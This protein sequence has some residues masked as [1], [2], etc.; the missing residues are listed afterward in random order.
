MSKR[1]NF[2]TMKTVKVWDRL[3]REVMQSSDLISD[4][5]LSRG[6]M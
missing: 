5:V 1:E 4:V 6:L 2:F 3:P